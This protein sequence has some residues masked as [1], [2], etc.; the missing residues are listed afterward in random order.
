MS[1]LFFTGSSWAALPGR[2]AI[3][4]E[5]GG[6]CAVCESSYTVTANPLPQTPRAQR[7][8]SLFVLIPFF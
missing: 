5:P 6:Q 3:A 8:C 7:I 4:A 1:A 2:T